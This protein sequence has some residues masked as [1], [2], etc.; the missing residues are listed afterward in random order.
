MAEPTIQEIKNKINEE[1]KKVSLRNI[2]K[3]SKVSYQTILNIMHG[4][5]KRVS[6]KISKRL[7]GYFANVAP[8]AAA[9][10]PAKAAPAKAATAKPA[11]KPAPVKVAPKAAAPVVKKRRRGR[12]PRATQ[13]Q[14]QPAM[15]YYFGSTLQGEI[16]ATRARL[17]YL[18]AIEKAELAFVKSLGK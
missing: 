11:A 2:A 1:N 14:V 10:A 18:M 17:D 13:P 6:R 5:S 3:L 15:K 12:P 8:K 4:K 16:S 9:P 7:M